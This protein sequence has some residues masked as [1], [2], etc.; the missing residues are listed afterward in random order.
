MFMQRILASRPRL[1][2][3][4]EVAAP[5]SATR[6]RL[7]DAPPAAV[8]RGGNRWVAIALVMLAV[9]AF[10]NAL[11]GEFVYDDFPY[12]VENVQVQQP[13]A[14][15]IFLEPFSGRAELGLYR[16]LP[17]SSYAWQAGGLGK[18]APSWPFHLFNVVCHAGVTLLVWRL[19]A[20][21][22][23]SAGVAGVA[24][25]L[26]AVHPCHVEGVDWIVGRAELMA[27]LFGLG[28]LL[29]A[30]RAR[31]SARDVAVAGLLLALAGLS[32][33]SS[34]A[35]PGVLV[36]VELALRGWPGWRALVRRNV[37]WVVV[38]AGLAALRMVAIGRFAP[39]AGTAPYAD[40][41]WYARPLLAA[42]LLGEYF[43]RALVPMPPRIFFHRAEFAQ[44]TTTTAIGM[45][46]YAA[47]LV[48]AWKRRPLRA[49]LLAFPVALATVLNLWPIQETLAERFLYLPSA[50]ALMLPALLLVGLVRWERARSGR[51]GATLLAPAAAIGGLLACTLTWNPIFDDALSLWRH[52]VSLAPELPFPHYQL[53]YF[54][55]GDKQ[56]TRNAAD[57]P[58]AVD[59]Y[60]T[61]IANNEA[62]LARGHEG[63]PPDQLINAY[64]SLGRIWLD[65]LPEGRRDPVRA[66]PWLE[67]AINLGRTLN[68][69]DSPL[70]QAY[71]FYAQLR[72]FP[73]TGVTNE[74][75][76]RALESAATLQVTDESRQAIRNELASLRSG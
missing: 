16:P 33:E 4:V 67:K 76:I 74:Q 59:E 73:Q 41:A 55:Y 11:R 17:L 75:A 8:G 40:V 68:G 39:A 28:F 45:A 47:S 60:E 52:N 65:L 64:V 61:A 21:L 54:L 14:R 26:F 7:D 46:L 37:P 30:S 3:G 49:A 53:A 22:G 36:V 2:P 62:L 29:V 66:K 23:F 5:A 24:A 6:S 10:A 72:R 32:K 35:L 27:A 25:A 12:I 48:F 57:R 63:M 71:W 18:D 19:A 50:F 58:G 20:R 56:Y 1:V 70:A 15:R 44:L 69:L 43:L 42:N 34:F 9:G 13:T 38:L 31:R 51:V